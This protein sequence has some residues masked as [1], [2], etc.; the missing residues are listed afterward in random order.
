MQ[1][2]QMASSTDLK[3]AEVIRLTITPSV[4][5]LADELTECHDGKSSGL[6]LLTIESGSVRLSGFGT[7][8]TSWQRAEHGCSAGTSDIDLFGYGKGVVDFDTE[9]AR[10]ALDLRMSQQQ[11]HRT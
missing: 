9:V 2:M 4:L 11:L 3:T 10:R 5:D 8:L 6:I 1:V 7:P